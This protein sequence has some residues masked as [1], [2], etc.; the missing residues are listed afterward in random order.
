MSSAPSMP[1]VEVQHLSRFFQPNAGILGIRP[2]IVHAVEDVSLRVYPGETLALVGESGCGK[3]TL[4]RLILRLIEPTSG[5]VFFKGNDVLRLRGKDL[6]SFRQRAQ[7]IFQDPVSSLNPRKTVL[8]T[9]RAPILLHHLAAQGEVR[10]MVIQLLNRVG[11]TPPNSYLDRYPHEF[12][13]GQRQ[14]IGIARAISVDP[15]FIVADE[16]V[17]AL[18]ISLRAQI[19]KLLGQLKEDMGVA[20]LFITHDLAVVRSI[21]DRVAVMYLGE[22]VESGTVEDIFERPYH[23]YTQALLSATPIADPIKAKQRTRFVLQGE[24]PSATSPPSGCRFHPRCPMSDGDR[25]RRESVTLREVID[26]RMA[27]CHYA[28]ELTLPGARGGSADAPD[29]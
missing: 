19:L 4:A 18:D 10:E 29:A 9:L 27:A 17:S 24:L 14:R 13:G 11:L 6:L 7:I 8:T 3:S 12:S 22:I 28:G 21:A 23:P 20:M 26:G 25:C 16:P 2:Q 1:L 15:I 5:S